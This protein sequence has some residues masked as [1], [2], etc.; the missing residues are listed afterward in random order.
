MRLLIAIIEVGGQ[1]TR[2]E[3]KGRVCGAWNTNNSVIFQLN[4]HKQGWFAQI[5]G[6]VS[7][8]DI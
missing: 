3:N 6:L 1:W 4:R 2:S 8:C 7:L 5:P